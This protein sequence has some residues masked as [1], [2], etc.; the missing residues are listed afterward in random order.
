VPGPKLSAN[1]PKANIERGEIPIAVFAK[2]IALP[3][4][5]S[6]TES[7]TKENAMLTKPDIPSPANIRAPTDNKYEFDRENM[8]K[9]KKDTK[10]PTIKYVELRG[11]LLL[12][13]MKTVVK[14][15]P[16]P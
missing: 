2:P 11:I 15:A 3:P 5:W 10:V 12:V 4:K 14:N 13:V 8:S 9:P 1:Q 7:S 16:N 6:S